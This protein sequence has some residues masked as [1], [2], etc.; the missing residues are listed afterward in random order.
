MMVLNKPSFL[1]IPKLYGGGEA[2]F[3]WSSVPDAAGYEL[4]CVFDSDFNDRGLT[5]QN[6]EAGELSWEGMELKTFAGGYLAHY[7]RVLP[8][9]EAR[10]GMWMPRGWGLH[11]GR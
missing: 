6:V 1:H 4:D 10:E 8:C 9:T 2:L 3:T 7:S 5:W 11:L